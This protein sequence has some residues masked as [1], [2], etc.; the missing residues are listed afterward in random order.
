MF[1]GIDFLLIL[2]T[3]PSREENLLEKIE[4][5]DA[6]V[7][8]LNAIE[9]KKMLD[10][11]TID[12]RYECGSEEGVLAILAKEV[13]KDREL[14][15][16]VKRF[17]ENLDEGY[18]SAECNMGEEEIEE[19]VNIL[20]LSKKPY[21]YV[22]DDINNHPKEGNIRKIVSLLIEFGEFKS[23]LE[24]VETSDLDDVDELDSFDGTIIYRC[25]ALNEEEKSSLLGSKQF[26]IAAKIKE[27]DRIIINDEIKRVFVNDKDLKGTVSLLPG[28]ERGDK[29]SYE[30]ARIVKDEV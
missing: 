2:A 23:N 30:I 12:S 22:G 16:H 29:Y 7:V 24:P 1:E 15:L 10:F 28:A 3:L 17:F 20:K 19:I 11:T 13:L 14:P 18:I 26:S 4:N 9:D 5:C 21:I 6:A 25:N 27:G 8:Y